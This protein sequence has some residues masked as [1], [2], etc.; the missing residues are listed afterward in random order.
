MK[1]GVAIA[2]MNRTDRVLP[3]VE[4]WLASPLVDTITLVDWSS[5]HEVYH[6]PGLNGLLTHP[7]IR[8]INV[9]GETSFIG[10]AH[11]YNLAIKYTDADMI[12][13]ADIDHVLLDNSFILECNEACRTGFLRGDV[14]SY[15]GLC[16]FTKSD[17]NTVGRYDERLKGWGYDDNS[18]YA[19]LIKRGIQPY[20]YQTAKQ[21]VYHIPHSNH[22]RT[23]NYPIKN[24]SLS[25]KR[26][27]IVSSQSSL[28]GESE[29]KIIRSQ[30]NYLQLK[31][32][33]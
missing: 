13:K 16:A 7:K 28:S 25:Q 1:I 10:I 12:V 29:Y 6:E 23:A 2:V 8:M 3:C 21:Y 22:M 24:I 11:S 32:I 4:S 33:V 20:Y 15:F 9:V 27:I 5:T 17:F 31:R 30:A 26:N 14:D 18:L 19:R